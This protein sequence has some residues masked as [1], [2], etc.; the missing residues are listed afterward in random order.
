MERRGCSFKK[1]PHGKTVEN[2]SA[3]DNRGVASHAHEQEA[4]PRLSVV[5]RGYPT[6][7]PDPASSSDSSG[8]G[9]RP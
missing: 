3:L 9:A 4:L 7:L 8:E 6:Y 5:R 2:F 1:F